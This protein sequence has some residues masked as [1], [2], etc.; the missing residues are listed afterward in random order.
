M[1]LENREALQFEEMWKSISKML[2][3]TGMMP[4][5]ASLDNEQILKLHLKL[6]NMGNTFR[7]LI[8]ISIL[9]KEIVNGLLQ[10][11]VN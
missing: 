5:K 9:K 6:R 3:P 1:I 11:L 2:N 7:D 4:D 8:Q 10:N